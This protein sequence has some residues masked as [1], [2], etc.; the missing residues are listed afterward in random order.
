[1][2]YIIYYIYLIFD[3]F[4]II[5]NDDLLSTSLTATRNE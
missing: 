3:I 4:H 2:Q 5:I 1:M